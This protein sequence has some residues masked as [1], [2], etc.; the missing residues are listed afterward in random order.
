MAHYRTVI[1]PYG[2]PLDNRGSGAKLDWSLWTAT[3]TQ[4]RAD[5]EAIMDPVYRFVD[6]TPQRVGMG[7]WY[8][9]AN[10]HHLFMHSRPVVGGVF[11]QM[12][13]DKQVWKKWASRD[14]LRVSGWAALPKPPKVST[15]VSA[16]DSSAQT[17]RYTTRQPGK[18]WFK[19]AFDDAKWSTGQSG[20][21]T[22]S[23]PGTT[24]R[25]EWSS[26]DIWIRRS[27]EIDAEN[28]GGLQLWIHHDNTA[29]VYI[30]GVLA[31]SLRGWTTS[32]DIRDI[33]PAARKALRAGAN[34]IAI[35]CHQDTG[36]QYIDAGFVTVEAK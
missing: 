25:T 5:F 29:D 9:T 21:G 12:L 35:H 19:P 17:W 11:L 3:L 6:E 31:C 7:D 2:L 22:A 26:S 13:Y 23:T 24:V 34:T 32:Y 20:F 33:S 36:G 1:K 4:N 30:N 15:V 10:G 28:I 27:F 8:D 16:G 14:R 18:D